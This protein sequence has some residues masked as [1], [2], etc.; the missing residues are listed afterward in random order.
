MKANISRYGIMNTLVSD[1]GPQFASRE[2]KQFIDAYGINHV[3]SF[4]YTNSQ[5]VWLNEQFK[6]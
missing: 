4:L 3:T 1:N 5:T 2:F 6:R